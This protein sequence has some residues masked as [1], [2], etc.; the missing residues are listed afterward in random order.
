MHKF[1]FS[2]SFWLA[3]QNFEYIQNSMVVLSRREFRHLSEE[4]QKQTE[5]ALLAQG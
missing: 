2:L 4:I 1:T 3:V 5:L